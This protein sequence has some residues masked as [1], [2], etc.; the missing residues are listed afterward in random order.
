MQRETIIDDLLA[1]L[2]KYGSLIGLILLG[3]IGMFSADLIKNRKFTTAYILGATGCG[4]FVGYVGGSYIMSTYPTRAPILIPIVTMLSQN[5]VS[6]LMA[7]NWKA[8]VA[9]DW[10]GAF[11]LLIRKKD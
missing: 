1:G 3:L 10:K 7:I 8:L 9:K 2:V 11:E 4:I 5:I 6:A